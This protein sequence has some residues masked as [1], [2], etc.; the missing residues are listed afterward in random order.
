MSE[1]FSVK[2]IVFTA[3]GYG[4]SWLELIATIAGL[5][6]VWLSA[7]ER[8]INWPIG[9]INVG[10][11]FFVFYQYNLYSDML[12]QIYFFITGVYGWWQWT[13][14]DTVSDEKVV[15]ISY[16]TR[17]QQ[18][19]M[20]G[21]IVIFTIVFG[22]MVGRFHE[23]FPMIFQ[24]PA[25]FPY[26]DTLIMVMSLFGNLLLTVKKIESWILWVLVDIIAPLIYFQKGML[27]F[28]IMYVIFLGIAIFALLNW[29]KIY[30][31]QQQTASFP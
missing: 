29:L 8:I 9:L 27:L 23:W 14:K 17:S 18:W 19:G 10:L 4:M 26:P 28:T 3:Y 6:A 11:S 13:R 30:R 15:K 7:K 24:Q 2:N 31:Q 25:A 22:S 16:L 5:L 21:A 12:L 1:F 20:V